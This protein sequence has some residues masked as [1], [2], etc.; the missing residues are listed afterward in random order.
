MLTK[1]ITE[2]LDVKFARH[3]ADCSDRESARPS[4]VGTPG[5]LYKIES[6]R[7][8]PIRTIPYRLRRQAGLDSRLELRLAGALLASAYQEHIMGI[9]K[10]QVKGRVKMA[11]GAIKQNTGRI[12]GSKKLQV[13]GNI[14]KMIGKVQ[15]KLGDIKARA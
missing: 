4:S 5:T 6:V 9:N 10:H 15:A 3:D 8:A 2:L 14:Q 7:L 11:K 1:F 13:K 12:V